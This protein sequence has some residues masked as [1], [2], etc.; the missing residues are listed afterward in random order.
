MENWR[1]LTVI[2]ARIAIVLT[3]LWSG[4]WWVVFNILD[5]QDAGL[6]DEYFMWFWIVT[7]LVPVG[8]T[9]AI[10]WVF[11]PTD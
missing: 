8:T 5:N 9:C 1:M 6:V 3:I 2:L 10:V 7:W 4:L 11:S